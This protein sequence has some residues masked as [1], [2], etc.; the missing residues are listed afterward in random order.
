MRVDD[1]NLALHRGCCAVDLFEEVFEDFL[2]SRSKFERVLRWP[3][4]TFPR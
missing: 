2:L 3:A 4:W 1:N